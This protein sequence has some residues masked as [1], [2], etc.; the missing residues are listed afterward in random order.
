MYDIGCIFD[1]KIIEIVIFICDVDL[2]ILSVTTNKQNHERQNVSS[3]F[4]K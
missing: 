1:G 2:K 4:V 3:F